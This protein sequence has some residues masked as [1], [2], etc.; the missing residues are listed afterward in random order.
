MRGREGGVR[1]IPNG[2]APNYLESG[3]QSTCN[4]LDVATHLSE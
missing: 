1:V 4:G 3:R 2:M